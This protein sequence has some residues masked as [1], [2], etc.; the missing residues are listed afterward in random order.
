M[1]WGIRVH[2]PLRDEEAFVHQ[3]ERA[4]PEHRRDVKRAHR[5][6]VAAREH[7][8]GPALRAH[9]RD[10]GR[11]RDGLALV[12]TAGED[13]AHISAV[14]RRV[15]R[16][17]APQLDAEEA[18]NANVR[19]R[20]LVRIKG[21]RVA[22][23][24]RVDR[25]HRQV[26]FDA[27]EG[28]A[29]DRAQRH[30]VHRVKVRSGEPPRFRRPVHIVALRFRRYAARGATQDKRQE[31]LLRHRCNPFESGGNLIRRFANRFHRRR[32]AGVHKGRIELSV[33][34]WVHARGSA[35]K[36]SCMAL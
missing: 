23:V 30:A 29:V 36:E 2:L 13:D 6:S 17:R 34:A 19:S 7:E 35:H 27:L 21:A 22:A 33:K 24:T 4:P 15:A 12:Q 11:T 18:R 1:R 5:L 32:R 10:G 20:Q 3:D 25:R 9:M 28:H 14:G 16:G 8:H 31:R 26:A